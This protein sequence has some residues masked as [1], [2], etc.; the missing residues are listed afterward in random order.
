MSSPTARTEHAPRHSQADLFGLDSSLPEGFTYQPEFLTPEEE[1]QLISIVEGLPLSEAQYKEFTARRRTVSYGSKYDYGKNVLNEAPS[2]PPFLMPLR[3]KVAQW[4]ALPPEEFVHGLVSEYRPG[5]PLGWHR[6]VPE[7]EV[8]VGISLAA[9]CRM[10]LRPYRPGERNR[11]EDVIALEL[12][13]RSAYRICG[14]ARWGWQHSVAATKDL[15]YSITFRTARAA[16]A[17]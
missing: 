16:P 13:P 2:L 12:E 3:A 5:T 11:R 15:R 6:D 1:M 17:K 7:F 9:L 10:R 14:T 4:A 8:I